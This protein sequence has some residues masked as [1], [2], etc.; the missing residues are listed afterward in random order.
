MNKQTIEK[1]I[2][3]H[4]PNTCIHIGRINK[5]CTP[6]TFDDNYISYVLID[7]G[8]LYPNITLCISWLL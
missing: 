6:L 4:K 5:A 2:T 1:N 8:G 7:N 3:I